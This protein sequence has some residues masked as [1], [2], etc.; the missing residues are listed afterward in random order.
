MTMYYFESAATDSYENLALEE[1]LFETLPQGAGLF[2]LWQ[3]RDAVII[4]RYQNAAEEIDAAFVRENG[5][6]VVRR[7]SGGGA[8]FHDLGGLNYTLVTDEESPDLPGGAA[9]A[10]AVW[11][12]CMAPLIGVLRGYGLDAQFSGRND[13]E[14]GGK[15]IAGCAQ[16]SRGGRTLHHGCILFDTDPARVAAALDPGEA[17]FISKSDRSVRARVTTIRACL[18]AQAP[19]HGVCTFADLSM[20]QFRQDLREAY[21]QLAAAGGLVPY[22]LTEE[23]RAAIRRL[24]DKKYRTWEWNFG[25]RTDYQVRRQRRFPA[26]LITAD[27]DVRHGSIGAVRF[28]GDFFASGDLQAFADSLAGLA[29]DETLAEALQTKGAEAVFAGISAGQL[30]ML[31]RG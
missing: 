4:G 6:A 26:G 24:R 3:N 22:V 21:G 10:D 16:Y 30:A 17:K 20:A 28:S 7:M 1:H 9:D 31:L 13:I 23:E 8:V 19:G 12:A 25:Y 5:I 2:M 14:I 29:L 18:A 15:K 27:M 11:R